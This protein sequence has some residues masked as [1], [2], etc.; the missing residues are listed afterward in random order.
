MCDGCSIVTFAHLH[1][2][3]TNV[4]AFSYV[5]KCGCLGGSGV[6]ATTLALPKQVESAAYIPVVEI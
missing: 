6:S 2:G 4:L 1:Q 3:V 5:I